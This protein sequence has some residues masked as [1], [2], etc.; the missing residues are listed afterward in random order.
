MGLHA[1]P[2]LVA[3]GSRLVPVVPAVTAPPLMGLCR[4]S[5]ILR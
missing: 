2:S 3:P 1:G 5:P 4:S